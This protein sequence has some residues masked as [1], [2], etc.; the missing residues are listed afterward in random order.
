LS[1]P[2]EAGPYRVGGGSAPLLIAGNCV[3]ETLDTA[4][5][6]A[7]VVAEGCARVGFNP[8][9]KASFEKANRSRGDSYRGPGLD[10]GLEILA[11]VKAETG[12]PLLTDVHLPEHC[13]PAGEVVDFLQIPAFL[14]RQTELL[15]AAAATGRCVN[16][17]KGQ[18]L[19]PAAMQHA[20]QKVRQAGNESVLLT[21]RGASF[22]YGDLIVD[23]RGFE[24][25]RGFAPLIFDATH[26]AQK[27]AGAGG[28]TGGDRRLALPLARAAA[29]VGVDGYFVELHPRPDEA[30]SDAANA[31]DFDLFNR[32]L[33]QTSRI[34]GVR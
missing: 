2:V 9:F 4:L 7:D 26:S 12:L 21:E 23:F 3:I 13:A 22:G 10:A 24:T 16:I 28:V 30:K 15:E 33:D 17:K 19:A 25:M 1:A 18:F 32:F 11:R 34:M 6:T 14:C 27:P 31:L 20:A 5:R 8:V 29:A